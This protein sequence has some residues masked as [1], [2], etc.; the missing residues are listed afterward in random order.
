MKRRGNI[1]GFTL[2]E[3]LVAMTVLSGG[4]LGVLSA[5]SLASRSGRS[6][7]NLR[8]AVAIAQ[9][10][11]ELIVNAPAG[12]ALPQR[13]TAGRYEWQ[14]LVEDLTPRLKRAT[15]KVNWSEGGAAREY[16]LSQVFRSAGEG[17]S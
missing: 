1:A 4:I 12:A 7:A 13:Q 8:Q 11:L 14:P 17:G 3:V 16:R 15:I 2:I 10:E 6:G 9:R 5:F